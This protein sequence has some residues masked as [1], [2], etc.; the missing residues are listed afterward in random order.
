MG[1]SSVLY[2]APSPFS[3]P[4]SLTEEKISLLLQLI[5]EELE[6]KME[7]EKSPMKFATE[8]LQV[9]VPA[10]ILALCGWTCRW[11]AVKD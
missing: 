8:I 6:H 11:V 9:H 1:S 5:G 10:C 2:Q 7:G 4:Q 3:V